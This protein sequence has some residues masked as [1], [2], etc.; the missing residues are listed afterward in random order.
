MAEVYLIGTIHTDIHGPNRLE[1]RLHEIKPDIVLVEGNHFIENEGNLYLF[2]LEQELKKKNINPAFIDV[3]LKESKTMGSTFETPTS[4]S[5][6]LDSG[7]EFD[8]LGDFNKG[9]SSA[10]RMIFEAKKNSEGYAKT[11]LEQFLQRVEYNRTENQRAIDEAWEEWKSIEGTDEEKTFALNR[12]EDITKRLGLF[13]GVGPRDKQMEAKL[14]SAISANP[15][16]RIASVIGY[17]HN[18]N[19]QNNRTLYRLMSVDSQSSGNNIHRVY[20]YD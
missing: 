20:L 1:K 3:I 11:T 2:F 10:F 7:A 8:Y 4:K 13:G 12:I 9:A 19:D 15:Q 16:S 14:K 5:Y 17:N 6:A 18:L